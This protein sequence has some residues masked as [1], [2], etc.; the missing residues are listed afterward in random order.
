MKV[1]WLTPE[2]IAYALIIGVV[3]G[4]CISFA[5]VP[6]PVE[7]PVQVITPV[8]TPEPVI[9][10][11]RPTPVP[12]PEATVNPNKIVNTQ[13][14]MCTLAETMGG[15]FPVM[16]M[17]M[18]FLILIFWIREGW[19][20]AAFASIMMFALFWYVGGFVLIPGG[21]CNLPTGGLP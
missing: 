13:Q 12:T 21:V 18:A 4:V 19:T 3:V 9:I 6:R 10:T 20:F 14:V 1:F 5:S 11:E 8:P 16:A 7:V 17:M 15:M 2:Q